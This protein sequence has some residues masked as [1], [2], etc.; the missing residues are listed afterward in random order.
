MGITKETR[1]AYAEINEIIELLSIEDKNKIPKKLLDFFEREKDKDYKKHIDIQKPLIEQG[2]KRK[3][4]ALLAMLNL[5]YICE[6]ENEKQRLIKSYKENDEKRKEQYKNN[7][8]F[9][10]EIEENKE[11][12]STLEIKKETKL[13]KIINK[14]K[15]F[16][17]IK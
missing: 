14:I 13:Q 6:D 8:M 11:I 9:S 15:R 10:K 3:T 1:V 2:I 5:N 12:I 4:L 16:F 17:H 7:N